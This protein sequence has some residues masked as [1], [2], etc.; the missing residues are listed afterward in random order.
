MPQVIDRDSATST[1]PA[2][3]WRGRLTSLLPGVGASALATAV[4]IGMNA[5]LPTLSPLLIAIVI[6]AV[7]ANVMALPARWRPGLQFSA[8]R[9]L[10]VGVALLGL[11]LMLSDILRLGAGMVGVVVAIVCL[12]I[13]A[14][15]L[16]GKV[17]GIP[18]SQR[19]LIACGFSICGA[20]AVAA[21]DGV[22]S[23]EDEEEVVTAVALVVIFGTLAIP[24]ISVLSSLLGMS[25]VEAGLWAGGSIHEVAQVVAA[26]GTIGGGA[27]GVAVV[28]KLARVL[29][30][31]PV[32]AVLSVRQRRI[33]G[34]AAD[35]KRPPLI[36]LFVLAFV[37][38]V[39]MRSTG[40]LPAALL[41]HAK[42][43]QTALLTA[44]MFAL[45]TGVHVSI[46]KK[47]GVR[48]FVLAAASTA[49]VAVIAL[50]GVL[51]ANG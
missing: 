26:A 47:V 49:W 6:G 23:T 3:L 2:E 39:V 1:S 41:G 38:C 5:W 8:K 16:A 40:M 35:I 28:V 27:L 31:A 29:M 25:S 19:L 32:M 46:F 13:A 17:L 11:Q 43:V 48:P 45:G 7:A 9:L 44:A 12:G 33:A 4:A 20:A 22:V 18:W 21:V 10:R 14:T 37:A 15:M 42:V 50:T 51:L 34:C 30:L 36:P 24:A